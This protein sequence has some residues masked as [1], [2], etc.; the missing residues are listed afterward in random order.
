MIGDL[1]R[2]ESGSRFEADEKSKDIRYRLL[3]AAVAEVGSGERARLPVLRFLGKDSAGKAFE[4]PRSACSWSL[5]APF[6]SWCPPCIGRILQADQPRVCF[7]KAVAS[8]GVTERGSWCKYL[9][10]G[11]LQE[12]VAMAETRSERRW[13][14]KRA[15]G[16]G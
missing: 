5:S 11:Q 4:R 6:L 3:S 10:L 9:N 13:L 12:D 15:D 14:S 1:V 8:V 16:R 7:Y 2:A